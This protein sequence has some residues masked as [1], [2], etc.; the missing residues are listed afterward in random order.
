MYYVKDVHQAS[1]KWDT[2]KA[3]CDPLMDQSWA[4]ALWVLALVSLE[5]IGMFFMLNSP[6]QPLRA[7]KDFDIPAW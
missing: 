4:L 5:S 2:Y 6:P 1:Q 7:F 3:L